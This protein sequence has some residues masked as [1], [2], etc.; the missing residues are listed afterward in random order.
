MQPSPPKF[1]WATFNTPQKLRWTAFI[2]QFNAVREALF[3]GGINVRTS[4]L[5]NDRVVHMVPEASALTSLHIPDKWR[6]CGVYFPHVL[7][8]VSFVLDSPRKKVVSATGPSLVGKWEI[9]EWAG[10]GGVGDIYV[11]L[12]LML[13]RHHLTDRRVLL[14]EPARPYWLD[15]Y[16]FLTDCM[17]F[18][19]EFN[20]Q[21]DRQRFDDVSRK[22]IYLRSN[23]GESGVRLHK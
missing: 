2:T 11:A 17:D 8:P 16:S 20:L 19:P 12:A 23:N 13:Y 22:G 15:A 10:G 6:S 7:A 3:A 4:A 9:E 14:L 1:V 5:V 21:R 18:R